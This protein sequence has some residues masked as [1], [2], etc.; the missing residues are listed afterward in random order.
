MNSQDFQNICATL[1]SKYDER[2]L[3]DQDV[4]AFADVISNV[5]DRDDLKDDGT[6]YASLSNRV[7]HDYEND[8]AMNPL[9]ARMYE[10]CRM[11]ENFRQRPLTEM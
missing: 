3:T 1:E 7:S 4:D 8:I 9:L 11:Y 6:D 2:R 10:L 5:L